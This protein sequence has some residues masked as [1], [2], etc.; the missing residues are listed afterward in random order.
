MREGGGTYVQRR[1]HP[2]TAAVTSTHVQDDTDAYTSL[3]LLRVS[4]AALRCLSVTVLSVNETSNR[5]VPL[6]LFFLY[7]RYSVDDS[8]LGRFA[9][10]HD[11]Y[12][13]AKGQLFPN[14]SPHR[15]LRFYRMKCA[16]KER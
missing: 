8:G 1:L 14:H 13:E 10:M 16:W 12:I 15:S 4:A 2:T 5:E 6:L 7:F 9:A 3:L 11:V